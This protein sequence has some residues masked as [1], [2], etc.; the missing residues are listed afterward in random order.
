MVKIGRHIV[1]Y[2]PTCSGKSTVAS[3]IA[4]SIEMPYIELDAIFWKPQWVEMPT[5]EFRAE[6]SALLNRYA[7]GWVFDGNYGR[8]RDLILPLAD[9]VVWLRPPFRVAFWR[10]LKR[11][12]IRCWTGE[13]LWGANR[14]SWRNQFMSRES[15]ILYTITRWRYQQERIRRALEE[16]PH[17]ASI[18]Q[19]RSPKEID[20]F[21]AGLCQTTK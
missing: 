11:A 7:D 1:V 10:V 2:G 5:E 21:L 16:I 9:T 20:A 17:Q 6:V 19:L 8:V 3:H 4:K 13:L 14:E 18:I 12:L 15:L